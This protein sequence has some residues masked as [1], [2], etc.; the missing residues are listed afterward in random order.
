MGSFER[1]LRRKSCQIRADRG[2]RGG[3]TARQSLHRDATV[4]AQQIHDSTPA[5]TDQEAG[6]G[7]LIAC[8]LRT[9]QRSFKVSLM[10][11]YFI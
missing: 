8:V 6:L 7:L 10:H 3:K 9:N 2:D 1:A 11:G 5:F 4:F